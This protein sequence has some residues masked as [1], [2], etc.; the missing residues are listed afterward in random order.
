[1]LRLHEQDTLAALVARYEERWPSLRYANPA[2][3]YPASRAAAA[4]E[5]VAAGE[6]EYIGQMPSGDRYYMVSGKYRTTTGQG[7]CDCQDRAPVDARFG[8]LCKH[9]IAAMLTRSLQAA[10]QDQL[11]GLVQA[12]AGEPVTLRVVRIFADGEDAK[13][14]TGYRIGA[15]GL[16]QTLAA[17]AQFAIT[18][19][20]LEATMA[21][22]GYGMLKAPQ[23]DRGFDYLYYLAP[24]SAEAGGQQDRRLLR[25]VDA[26]TI[27]RR[28]ERH[29]LEQMAV[30][31]FA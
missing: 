15:R 1:M 11:A 17:D 5:L 20:G 23:R 29:R 3:G 26:A 14:V 24:V 7:R 31:A 30:A 4:A 21:A 13:R 27:E 18:N 10:S 16:W 8:K 2:A 25:A 9:R 22:V 12:A 28:E 6:V 19:G